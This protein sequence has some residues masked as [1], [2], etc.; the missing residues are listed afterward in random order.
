MSRLAELLQSR[1]QR[2]ATPDTS[3]THEPECSNR[4]KSSSASSVKTLSPELEC[5][6]R[7]M[8]QRWSYASDDLVE[9]LD[10]A[11]GNPAAWRLAVDLDERR[12]GTGS[13]PLLWPFLKHTDA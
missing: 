8:A 1:S 6:I 2:V 4:S 11:R 5:R 13:E 12:F 3:A 7:T 10:L 9:V